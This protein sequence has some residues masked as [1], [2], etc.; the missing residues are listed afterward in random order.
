MV[1]VI[2]SAPMAVVTVAEG[3]TDNLAHVLLQFAA[4]PIVVIA[5]VSIAVITMTPAQRRV[6]VGNPSYVVYVL[7]SAL[8]VSGNCSHHQY[9]PGLSYC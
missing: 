4:V 9:L 6:Q 1:L 3:V 8:A 7:T 5:V 2:V